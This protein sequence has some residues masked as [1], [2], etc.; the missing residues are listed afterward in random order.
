MELI[1]DALTDPLPMANG[2]RL[3]PLPIKGSSCICRSEGRLCWLLGDFA[4]LEAGEFCIAGRASVGRSELGMVN[5]RTIGESAAE[6]ASPVEGDLLLEDEGSLSASF[7][8]GLSAP[9][10]TGSEA[11][12]EG[13]CALFEPRYAVFFVASGSVRV[14]IF[15][16]AGFAL[17]LFD[18]PC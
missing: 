11:L 17:S 16:R 4:E 5:L 3:G 9:F 12:L 13:A 15:R 8:F 14:C 1:G 18:V 6:S 10:V 7:P 2:G